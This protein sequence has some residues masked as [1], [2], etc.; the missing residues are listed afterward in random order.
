MTLADAR[1]ETEYSVK[2]IQSDDDDLIRF[3]FSLGCYSGEKI[4]VITKKKNHVVLAIKDARYNMD[5]DLAR[6]IMI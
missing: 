1:L 3:L 5:M 4:T 2:E 6:S